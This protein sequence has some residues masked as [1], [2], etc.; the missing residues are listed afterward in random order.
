MNRSLRP[1]S[2]SKV[3]NNE[4]VASNAKSAFSTLGLEEELERL[5]QEVCA[6]YLQD[7]VPWVVGYSGGKDSTAIVQLIWLALLDLPPVQRRKP[8]FVITTDTLVENPIVS[9]WVA[10]SLDIMRQSARDNDL[11][12]FPEQLTPDLQDTFWVNLIGKGYPAPRPKFR[13]CTERLKI[14]P[15]DRF[16]RNVVEQNGE[17]IV[18]LGTRKAESTVRAARL[19]QLEKRRVRDLLTPHSSLQNSLVYAPISDW[20]NDDVWL[21]LMQRTNPWGYNNK[22]LLTMYQGA[23]ADGECPLVVDTSTPSCGNSRF[24]CWVCT[25]V[26]KD[27]SMSAMIQ[28]DDEKIWMTPLLAL[29]N[30]LDEHDHDKRDFRR[31][32][33]SINLKSQADEL[34]PGPYTQASRERWLTRLLAVQEAIR[35][36]PDTPEHVRDLELI[37]VR[38]L[39]EVRRIWVIEKFEIEDSVPRI[40]EQVTGREYPGCELEGSQPFGRDEMNI[41]KE[42]VCDGNELK[43]QLMRELLEVQRRYRGATRR[44]GL[45]ERLEKAYRRSFFEDGH[46]ALQLAL[47]RKT[48]SKALESMR[49]PEM[50][51]VE[52]TTRADEVKA[53]L[54]MTGAAE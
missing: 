46:D 33:G 13:W 54:S 20:S 24:G 49:D 29:R 19:N 38:E 18:V 42:Q 28:N 48:R 45:F 4:V 41:L 7:E 5:K 8:V 14:K 43:F 50:D 3:V 30:E 12:F 11:P 32:N 2:W 1:R 17:A 51:S 16:V 15:V 25:L 44:A 53:I 35:T 26:D 22:D 52:F 37:T 6:L 27:R 21:F 23:T 36:D 47:K 10:K 39:E 40:F 31:L 9:T 34:V